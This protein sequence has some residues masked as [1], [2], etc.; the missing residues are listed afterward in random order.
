MEPLPW[1]ER[2][3]FIGLY[4]ASCLRLLALEVSLQLDVGSV[5]GIMFWVFAFL[6]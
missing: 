1:E 5:E 3:R 6:V 4:G 2:A